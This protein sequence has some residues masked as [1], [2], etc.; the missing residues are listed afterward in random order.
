MIIRSI[1]FWG[2]L[3]KSKK[4]IF[5]SN[6]I[7]STGQIIIIF[8]ETILKEIS[9]AQTI[10]IGRESVYNESNDVFYALAKSSLIM[11]VKQKK[12]KADQIILLVSSWTI[13]DLGLPKRRKDIEML[14]K[15]RYDYPKKRFLETKEL[16]DVLD[17]LFK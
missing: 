17:L 14:E 7:N 12:V 9:N 10:I 1:S 6:F 5:K 3:E 13:D 2:I 8:F 16:A 4:E 15:Y 11:N